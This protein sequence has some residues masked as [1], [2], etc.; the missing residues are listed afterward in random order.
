MATNEFWVNSLLQ[1]STEGEPFSAI[2]HRQQQINELTP[3]IV[4]KAAREYLNT[5][6]V[7]RLVLKPA[8]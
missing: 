7:G 6:N 1:L 5:K 8:E 2:Q 4:L 3:D